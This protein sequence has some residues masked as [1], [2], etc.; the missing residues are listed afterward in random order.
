MLTCHSA[1][2]EQLWWEHRQHNLSLALLRYK[3]LLRQDTRTPK[4]CQSGRSLGSRMGGG[5]SH[6][7]GLFSSCFLSLLLLLWMSVDVYSETLE[8]ERREREGGRER[9]RE[10]E[11]ERE[12][13]GEFR[14]IT[15]SQCSPRAKLVVIHRSTIIYYSYL[16]INRLLYVDRDTTQSSS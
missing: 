12:R 5:S 4:V 6:C 11:G 15:S 16:C 8:K 7:R 3:V 1:N 13:G 9:E 14:K 10:R 2:G